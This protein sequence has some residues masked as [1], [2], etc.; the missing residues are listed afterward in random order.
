MVNIPMNT[1]DTMVR[2]HGILRCAKIHYHTRTRVT[3]FGNTVGLPI[4][5]FNPNEYYG[6]GT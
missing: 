2:V 3:R 5:V 1:Q 4:P 6:T